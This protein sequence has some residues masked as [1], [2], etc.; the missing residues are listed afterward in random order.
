MKYIVEIPDGVPVSEELVSFDMCRPSWWD[1]AYQKGLNDAWETAQAICCTENIDELERMGFNCLFTDLRANQHDAIINNSAFEVI[2]LLKAWKWKQN[3]IKVGDE[4]IFE[5]DVKAVVVDMDGRT[6]WALS[7]V[8]TMN[9][10]DGTTPREKTGRFFPQ[11]E[12]L[13]KK[14]QE[15][16]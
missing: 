1:E 10:L 9:V 7:E 14:M 2:K 4:I 12:E 16:E 8:G 13:L 15:E 5:G 3:E 11:V 6:L